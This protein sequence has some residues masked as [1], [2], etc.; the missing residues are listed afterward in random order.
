MWTKRIYSDLSLICSI[1]GMK[2]I[3][4]HNSESSV[5]VLKVSLE[6]MKLLLQQFYVNDTLISPVR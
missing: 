6:A 4:Q 2:Q 3:H 1:C 5:L